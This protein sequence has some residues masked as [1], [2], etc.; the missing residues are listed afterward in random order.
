MKKISVVIPA[1]NCEKYIGRCINSLIN[2]HGAEL[3]II[4]VNDGSTDGT[5]KEL[6]QFKDLI[7]VKS[8]ENSG[9][10]AARNV[11]LECANGD[12]LMFVDSDD[13]LCENAIERLVGVQAENDADIV[14]FRYE[15]V[16]SDGSKLVPLS[17]LCE[18]SY[19]TK[20][21]FPRLV[22]PLFLK[23][24]YLNSV[25]MSLFKRK[26]VEG[27]RFRTDMSTAE[28]AVFS[29]GAFTKAQS[30][31][32]VSDIIYKYYQSNEGLTGKG[33]SVRKKYADNFR[34]AAESAKHLKE[35]GMNT[36]INFVK[37][38]LRPFVVTVDKVLRMIGKK[39][40][41]C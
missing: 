16:Y 18:N 20:E 26:I 11:G 21:D 22:Y 4:V 28:D 1:Y 15:Y 40:V 10:S 5:L 2:Q 30:V 32:V 8:I 23:G 7:T 13:Y 19:I 6:E 41:R 34:F 33:L 39:G 29:L 31:Q 14:R 12:F 27:M 35:W 38:Y 37:V 9:A 3:E 24:I 36:P 25:C 17:Q